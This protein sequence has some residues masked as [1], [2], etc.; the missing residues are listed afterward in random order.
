MRIQ[1]LGNGKK[2]SNRFTYH[3]TLDKLSAWYN[4][5]KA[6]QIRFLMVSFFNIHH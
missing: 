4:Q 5:K 3:L 2:K 1:M 6:G